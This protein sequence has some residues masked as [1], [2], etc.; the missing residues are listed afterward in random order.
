MRIL[1]STIPTTNLIR[2]I[3]CKLSLC[4]GKAFSLG[5]ENFIEL[6]SHLRLVPVQPR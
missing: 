6:E 1:V 2:I 3:E 4:A 5:K